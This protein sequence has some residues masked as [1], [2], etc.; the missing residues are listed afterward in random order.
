MSLQAES[1]GPI[2]AQTALVAH[3]AFPK[4]TPFMR[5]RDELGTIYENHPFADLFSSRGQPAEMPWRLALVTIM[6]FAE[7]LTDRQ[8]AD[9]VRGHIDWKY[10]LGLELTDSG[11]DFS[12]LSKFR[13]RLL[14]GQAEEELLNIM[15]EC[16]KTKGLLKEGG[17]TRTDSTHVLAAIRV[18][19]RL[20]S[21]GETLRAALNDL[22]TVMPQWLRKQ[23]SKE[24]FERYS[25]RFET[26][27]LPKEEAERHALAEIIGQDGLHL[28]NAVYHNPQTP[29]WLRE[30]PSVEILRRNWLYQFWVEEG[31]VRL[32]KA[33]DLP[34]AGL[35]IDSPYDPEA[36]YGNKRSTVWTGYKVHLSETCA[37]NEIHLITHVETTL[38]AVT[39]VAM[40]EPIHQALQEKGILPAEHLVDAGYVDADLIV[41]SRKDYKVELTGPVRPNSS[42]QASTEQGF[43]ISNFKIDWE[44]Q[45]VT[46]PMGKV[47]QNWRELRDH[48]NNEVVQARFSR[49]D[50]RLCEQRALCTKSKGDPRLIRLRPRA[51]HEV[52]QSVR[53]L[54]TTLEWK[55]QYKARAGIEGTLSQGVGGFGLRRCRYLGLAKTHLQHIATAA[56]INNIVRWSAWLEGR[57]HAPTRTSRFAS[58]ALAC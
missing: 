36:H 28:L 20:E 22:V 52:L 18:L 11:F 39:D 57:P 51:D 8:A 30:I 35:R 50:C 7:G 2:P 21:I 12:V 33:T 43:D 58:L 17:R 48:F 14:E 3:A 42:W 32:R 38:A 23:V 9:A 13:A 1:I 53:Q 31:Q 5:M 15:L 37:E 4:S 26:Y 49:T 29:Q 56:A 6:Q 41:K 34:P 40:T 24:W 27:R 19:H 46:C 45:K 16:F 25:T 55:A 44:A 10:T 47:S 54:Q